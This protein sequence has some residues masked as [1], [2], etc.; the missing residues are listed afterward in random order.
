MGSYDRTVAAALRESSGLKDL[1]AAL[2]LD[3]PKQQGVDG[4]DDQL[5]QVRL[6]II[7]AGG[8]PR[9]VG[10]LAKYRRVA[11][12]FRRTASEVEWVD[13]YSYTAHEEAYL[14]GMSADEFR[15]NPKQARQL[16]QENG[17]AS[18]DGDPAK[19]V[20][21][22][23]HE[24]RLAAVKTIAETS[25]PATRTEMRR[26]IDDAAPVPDRP[27]EHDASSFGPSGISGAM[28]TVR[29][30]IAHIGKMWRSDASKW[31]DAERD[32]VRRM[33]TE[34]VIPEVAA[35]TSTLDIVADWSMD[36]LEE[37]L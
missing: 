4:V 18:K 23:S 36:A 7:N 17:R 30:R 20:E 32:T 28:S 29:E 2:A 25:G 9:E 5:K 6:E 21:G 3:I 22:W 13:G 16:R 31:T 34:Q 37:V 35:T 12:H 14:T 8:E 19:V 33:W 10:T 1:A 24:Q 26:T 11:L 15:A 27:V